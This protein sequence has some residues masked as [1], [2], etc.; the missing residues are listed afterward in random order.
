M[1]F[2][3]IAF[4]CETEDYHL[5][6]IDEMGSV[7][8]KTYFVSYWLIG[9][10]VAVSILLVSTVAVAVHAAKTKCSC[11]DGTEKV[12]SLAENGGSG[13]QKRSAKVNLMN[14]EREEIPRKAVVKG[15]GKVIGG[16]IAGE[17]CV[18]TPQP[19]SEGHWEECKD[20]A[21]NIHQCKVNKLKYMYY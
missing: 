6:G 20:H 19:G 8:D 21:W 16:D 13:L 9:A 11:P 15:E 14:L 18:T 3:R 2:T 17:E 10:Y 12:E 1:Q 7:K 5:I 4:F